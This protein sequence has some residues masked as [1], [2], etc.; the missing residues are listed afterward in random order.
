M[1]DL[2]T[3]QHFDDSLFQTPT[4]SQDSVELLAELK[5]SQTYEHATFSA[6]VAEPTAAIPLLAETRSVSPWWRLLALLTGVYA[7]LEWGTWL[8]SSLQQ[9]WLVG[10]LAVAITALS[11]GLLC[12]FGWRL[13]TNRKQILK[14]QLLRERWAIC[15]G[16]AQAQQIAQDSATALQK[17]DY[18]QQ[19]QTSCPTHLNGQELLHW[20]DGHVLESIDQQVKSLSRQAALQTGVAVALSPFALADMLIVA[21][22]GQALIG[23]IAQAYGAEPDAWLRGSLLKQHMQHV[24]LAGSA[25][26]LTDLASDFLN[27]ELASKVSARAGQGVLASA[28][29]LRLAKAAT[30]TFRPAPATTTELPNSAQVLPELLN[31]LQASAK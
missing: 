23:Q 3:T 17:L 15:D 2:K 9:H 19:L 11:G 25:E 18:W 1:T 30:Q 7:A 31:R 12:R 13:R 24:V 26:M 16:R 14:R 6:T 27:A 10:G 29:M 20:F 21:W 8:V 28:L 5:P 4:M 22:R